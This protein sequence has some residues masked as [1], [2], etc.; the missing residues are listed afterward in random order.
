MYIRPT[1][2]NTRWRDGY[3]RIWAIS[4]AA[5]VGLHVGLF[6]FMPRALTDRLH[7]AMIPDPSVLVRAGPTGPMEA[8]LYR[9]PSEAPPETPPPPLEEEEQVEPTP[10]ETA[11]EEITVAEVTSVPTEA[12]GSEEGVPESTGEGEPAGGGGGTVSPPRPLHLVV[13]RVP[14]GVDKRR[15]RG[16]SVHLLV[17]VLAD[18]SVGRVEVEKGSR[19]EAL[20]LAALDAARR[21]RYMPAE[22]SGSGTAQW[23]RAEMRF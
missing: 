2:T 12:V 22:G 9:S 18:G 19:I 21:M 4:L 23:T 15:A 1:S 20:N 13:P 8:I 7:E 6:F 10:T 16:E 17:E 5:A 11:S 3:R 14:S